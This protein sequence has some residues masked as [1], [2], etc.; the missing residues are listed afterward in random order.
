MENTHKGDGFPPRVYPKTYLNNN[1]WE[2]EVVVPEVVERAEFKLDSTGYFYMGYCE[3]C[4]VS[5]FYDEKDLS[6][7]SKWCNAKLLPAKPKNTINNGRTKNL[8]AQSKR[9]RR[10]VEEKNTSNTSSTQIGQIIGSAIENI[11]TTSEE[12]DGQ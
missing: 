9:F 8:V 4:T 11:A 6:Q 3:K 7:D 1:G 10:H 2:D 12:G 5:D